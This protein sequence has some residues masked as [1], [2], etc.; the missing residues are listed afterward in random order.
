MSKNPLT[1]APKQVYQTLRHCSFLY[2]IKQAT[3]DINANVN[4]P[5]LSWDSGRKN[6]PIFFWA[7]S[8]AYEI[9]FTYCQSYDETAKEMFHC[10]CVHV[11]II[12]TQR[13]AQRVIHFQFIAKLL[14]W[15]QNRKN[16][17]ILGLKNIEKMNGS[18]CKVTRYR[19]RELIE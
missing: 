9:H 5:L 10:G 3:P 2:F 13:I 11:L 16:L 4:F 19:P 12:I 14:S 15:R 7:I 8:H 6:F 17:R 18:S 1:T